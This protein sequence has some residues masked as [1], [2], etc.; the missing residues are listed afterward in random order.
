MKASEDAR[1]L[2]KKW[3]S[4]GKTPSDIGNL[5]GRDTSS[6]T[7]WLCVQKPIKKQG[8]PCSLTAAQVDFLEKKLDHMI[9]AA[10]GQR[11]ITIQDLKKAAQCKGILP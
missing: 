6:V 3:H 5:L 4:Q 8:R 7:R 2:A 10:N 11:A 1:K 9:I